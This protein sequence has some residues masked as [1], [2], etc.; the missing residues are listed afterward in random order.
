MRPVGYAALCIHYV[1]GHRLPSLYR[2]LTIDACVAFV[3][4]FPISMWNKYSGGS[5]G[6]RAPLGGT[7]IAAA[8]YATISAHGSQSV[9]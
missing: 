1:D 9:L 6:G 3:N 4:G 2:S 5:K 8:E 7:R